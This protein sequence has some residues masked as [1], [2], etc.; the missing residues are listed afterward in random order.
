MN[1]DPSSK[2]TCAHKGTTYEIVPYDDISEQLDSIIRSSSG[3]WD[4]SIPLDLFEQ[5]LVPMD[6]IP[7][8]DFGHGHKTI[9][10]LMPLYYHLANWA[11]PIYFL[12]DPPDCTT[13][14]IL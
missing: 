14:T 4:N 2:V 10:L 1:I 12:S 13:L 7:N 3:T 6:I 11:K 9:T 5:R 8:D